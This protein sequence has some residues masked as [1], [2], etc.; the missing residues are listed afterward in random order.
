[1]KKN[2]SI[3]QGVTQKIIISLQWIFFPIFCPSGKSGTLQYVRKYTDTVRGKNHFSQ[4]KSSL[5]R[6]P[7]ITG[8]NDYNKNPQFNKVLM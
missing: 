1:M 4:V 8:V 5:R 6:F 3:K 7:G 2:T